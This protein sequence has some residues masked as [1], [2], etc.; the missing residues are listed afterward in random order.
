MVAALR[1]HEY[2]GLKPTATSVRRYAAE[3]ENFINQPA[4]EVEEH[5]NAVGIGLIVSKRPAISEADAF[6]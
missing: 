6:V 3:S 2:R 1:L 5:E 4:S